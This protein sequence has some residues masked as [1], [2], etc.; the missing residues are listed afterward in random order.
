MPKKYLIFD[1][2]PLI[3]FSMNGLVDILEKLQKE[4][5]GE[6]LITKEVKEEI[7]DNPL[8]IKKFELEALRLE[9]LFKKGIIK[10][11]DINNK[12]VE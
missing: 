1:A 4:F 8:N 3:N 2:G 7:I 6:F 10:H 9:T 5:K 11:A 12:Q